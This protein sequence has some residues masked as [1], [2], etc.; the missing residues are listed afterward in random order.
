[1]SSLQDALDDLT[2][3]LTS[4]ETELRK[5]KSVADLLVSDLQHNIDNTLASLLRPVIE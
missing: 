4:L 3:R 1:L 5:Y 2:Q